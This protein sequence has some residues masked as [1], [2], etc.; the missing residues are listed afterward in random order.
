MLAA[1][2]RIT[3]CWFKAAAMLAF[4]PAK[5]AC[6]CVYVRFLCV[7]FVCVCVLNVS[8]HAVRANITKRGK[9]QGVHAK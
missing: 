6:V 4:L 1:G 7:R 9:N 8:V 5:R 3:R 2:C